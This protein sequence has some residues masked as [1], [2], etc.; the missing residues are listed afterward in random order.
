MY[1]MIAEKLRCIPL[2]RATACCWE[3]RH[4]VIK[5]TVRNVCIIGDTDWAHFLI[6]RGVR[7]DQL[8]EGLLRA[9]HLGHLETVRMLVHQGADVRYE[10][11]GALMA[12]AGQGHAAVVAFLLAHGADP[13]A[14]N[15]QALA[16]VVLYGHEDVEMVLRAAGSS[17]PAWYGSYSGPFL[18]E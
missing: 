14:S 9:C 17:L 6:D 4:Y 18:R 3:V 8:F 13:R 5:P 10:R 12:A 15:D 1:A 7:K 11:D 2:T 16:S